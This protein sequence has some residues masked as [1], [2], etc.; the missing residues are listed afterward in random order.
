MMVGTWIM[1][2]Q[3]NWSECMKNCCSWSGGDFTLGTSLGR[4]TSDIRR[5]QDDINSLMHFRNAFSSV[6][7]WCIE[8]EIIKFNFHFL[9]RYEENRGYKGETKSQSHREYV[10]LCNMYEVIMDGMEM[11]F[12]TDYFEIVSITNSQGRDRVRIINSIQYRVIVRTHS[13][14]PRQFLRNSNPSFIGKSWTSIMQTLNQPPSRSSSS[15]SLLSCDIWEWDVV[16]SPKL[17][18]PSS[19]SSITPPSVESCP[20]PP[21]VSSSAA[22]VRCDCKLTAWQGLTCWQFCLITYNE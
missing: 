16:I 1:T 17:I 14:K 7:V 2:S 9:P 4:S 20:A 5:H 12:I 3:R 21:V 18:L 10:V 11:E 8:G 19:A 22:E 6:T 15:F 13:T